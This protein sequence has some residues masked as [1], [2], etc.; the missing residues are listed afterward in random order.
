VTR[1]IFKED[2]GD[3]D[4]QGKKQQHPLSFVGF[5]PGTHC[6]ITGERTPALNADGEPLFSSEQNE[7]TKETDN[8][9]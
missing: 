5:T 6:L 1:C 3:L 4:G 8:A 9:S 7:T 2:D